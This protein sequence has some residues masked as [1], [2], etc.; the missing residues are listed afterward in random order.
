MAIRPILALLVLAAAVAAVDRREPGAVSTPARL[1]RDAVRPTTG[2]IDVPSVR[3]ERARGAQRTPGTTR[4]PIL[5]YH[6]LGNPPESV[7]YPELYVRPT[8]FVAQMRWLERNGYEAVTLRAVWEHWH[9]GEPLP[10]RPVVISIDDGFRS[11]AVVALPELRRRGWP[12]VLNLALHHLDLSWGLRE[13]QIRELIEAGWEIDAHTLTHPDLTSVGDRQLTLEV[14]GS[15]KELQRRFGVPV[16][17][18]CYPSGRYDARVIA[19]VR[20][21]GYLGATTTLDGLA[22]PDE[23]FTLRRVRVNRSD[24]LAGLVSRIERVSSPG[25]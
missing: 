1:T 21:A 20:R 24:G 19:A 13:R 12:G 7:P 14:A 11:T 22:D 9:D 16:D 18:F 8:D 3:S 4:V 10:A 15:R 6:V 25:G 17:F 23:P 2:P 5:M